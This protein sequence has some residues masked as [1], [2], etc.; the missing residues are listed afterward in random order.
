[1]R[2]KVLATTLAVMMATSAAALAASCGNTAQ[3]FGGFLAS[4]KKQ[5]AAQGR[6]NTIPQSSSVIVRK[7]FLRKVSSNFR[8]AWHL[9]TVLPVVAN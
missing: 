8:A 3:G 1:M 7:M 6:F 9:I 4:V 2:L 5:A